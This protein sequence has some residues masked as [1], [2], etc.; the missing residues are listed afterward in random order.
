[1][2]SIPT[3]CHDTPSESASDAVHSIEQ[4]F[5]RLVHTLADALERVESSDNA[6]T[7]PLLTA[8]DAAQRGLKLSQDL[9]EL[10]HRNQDSEAVDVVELIN[11]LKAGSVNSV[12][13]TSGVR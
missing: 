9:T 12:T 8:R 4:L 10:L 3:S 1:M 2:S 6:L 7:E 13:A 11:G 5:G